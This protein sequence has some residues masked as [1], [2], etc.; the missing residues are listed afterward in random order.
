MTCCVAI[1]SKEGD[2]WYIGKICVVFDV[3][4]MPYQNACLLC[5]TIAT[6]LYDC[7]LASDSVYRA[8][9]VGKEGFQRLPSTSV[10]YSVVTV[11]TEIT[12]LSKDFLRLAVFT[13]FSRLTLRLLCLPSSVG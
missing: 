2:C 7:I 1:N 8:Q 4:Q 12:R 11:F 5:Y 10:L 3:T 6:E 13:E 9:S